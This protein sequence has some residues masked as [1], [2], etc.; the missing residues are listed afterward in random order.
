MTKQHLTLA[1]PIAILS[2]ALV[3][4]AERTNTIVDVERLVDGTAKIKIAGPL[5][6]H[7][8]IEASD[9]LAHWRSVTLQRCART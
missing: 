6:K 2:G 9:D 1:L 3:L 8:R 7:Y 5:G 4:A